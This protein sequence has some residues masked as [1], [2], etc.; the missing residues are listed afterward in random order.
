MALLDLNKLNISTTTRTSFLLNGQ[1]SRYFF[2]KLLEISKFL[3][4]LFGANIR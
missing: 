3:L 1:N 4:I 2:R